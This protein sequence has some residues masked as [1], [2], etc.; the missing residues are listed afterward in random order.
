MAENPAP[1]ATEKEYKWMGY[2]ALPHRKS[3]SIR[4]SGST[5]AFRIN[6]SKE[7]AW[8]EVRQLAKKQGDVAY[9]HDET[10]RIVTRVNYG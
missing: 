1:S 5:R 3:W 6:L 7:Q 10:G 4:K 2:H 9:C 8:K